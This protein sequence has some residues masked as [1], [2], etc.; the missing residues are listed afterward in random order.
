VDVR[1]GVYPVRTSGDSGNRTRITRER[2]SVVS[3]GGERGAIVPGA[4]SEQFSALAAK[5]GYPNGIS[6]NK[7]SIAP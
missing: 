4:F 5:S 3:R 1:V 6:F 7:R 2:G